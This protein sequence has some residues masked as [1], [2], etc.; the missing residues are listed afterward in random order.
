MAR[1][2][3]IVD[4]QF[5]TSIRSSDG[6]LTDR[7]FGEKEVVEAAELEGLPE[8]ALDNRLK[9]GFLRATLIADEPAAETSSTEEPE[10]PAGGSQEPEVPAG[11]E[12][13]GSSETGGSSDSGTEGEEKAPRRRK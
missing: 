2:A 4:K 11:T 8:G 10:V 5:T 3:L 7:T 13:T 1:A 12:G 9:H 6:A